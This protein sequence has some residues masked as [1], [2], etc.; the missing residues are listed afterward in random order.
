MRQ[1]VNLDADESVFFA[2]KLEYIKTQTY[3]RKYPELKARTLIPVSFEVPTGAKSITWQSWDMVGMAKIISNYA[4]DIPRVDLVGKEVTSTIKSL[5]AGYGYS[6]QDVRSARLAGIPLESRKAY[7]AKQAI[8]M[9]EDE[10]AVSGEADHGLVGLLNHPN[11][12]D[13]A[14]PADGTGSSALWANKTG[15]LIVRDINLVVSGIETTT[16]GVEIADTLIMDTVSFSLI[17]TKKFGDTD[18]TVL[19]WIKEVFPNL[20]NIASW[21][22]LNGKGAGATG[23]MVA[24]RRDPMKLTLEIPQD[25]EQLPVQEV[26]LEYIVNCHSRTGGVIIY[27]PLSVAKADGI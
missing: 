11:V 14:I 6:L 23:M 24:Y 8:L 12:P 16:N 13:I 2:R 1:F 7:A 20:V 19:T 9:A 17:K 25:F 26:G 22:K 10:I 18:K 3:D 15:E 5:G 21:A 4:T 27:Y